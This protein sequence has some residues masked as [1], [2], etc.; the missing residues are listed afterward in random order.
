MQPPLCSAL[1]DRS[2]FWS[3]AKKPPADVGLQVPG[4]PFCQANGGPRGST[5]V[6]HPNLFVAGETPA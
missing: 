3:S 2:S 6:L 4:R 5:Q 1:Q